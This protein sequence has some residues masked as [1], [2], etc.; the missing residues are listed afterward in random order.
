MRAQYPESGPSLVFGNCLVELVRAGLAFATCA[1]T[2][3]LDGTERP[4]F[5]AAFMEAD[6]LKPTRITDDAIRG[7]FQRWRTRN[8]VK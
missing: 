3:W 2:T 7:A 5:E 1:R 6:L 4:S 8:K